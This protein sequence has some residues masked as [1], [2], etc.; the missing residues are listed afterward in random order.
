MATQDVVKTIDEIIEPLYKETFL[1]L[2]GERFFG[3]LVLSIQNG[4]LGQVYEHPTH[5]EKKVE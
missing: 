5:K 1:N 3:Q 4:K 2:R